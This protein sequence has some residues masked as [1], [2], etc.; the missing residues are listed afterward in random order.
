MCT[1]I[2]NIQQLLVII[3]NELEE[4]EQLAIAANNPYVGN[5]SVN[6][7]IQLINNVN[8]FEKGLNA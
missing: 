3:F 2:F 1:K 8:D 5:Q 6:I 4:L 7:S